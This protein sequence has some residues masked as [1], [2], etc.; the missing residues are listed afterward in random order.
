MLT[1]R[2]LLL[3]VCVGICLLSLVLPRGRLLPLAV[4]FLIPTKWKW[5]LESP[6]GKKKRGV[7]LKAEEEAMIH[8]SKTKYIKMMCAIYSLN[9]GRTPGCGT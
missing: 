9:I 3:A 6:A 2:L 1:L 5:S 8:E 7:G 4:R